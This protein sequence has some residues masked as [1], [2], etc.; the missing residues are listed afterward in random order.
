MNNNRFPISL[1]VLVLLARNNGRLVSS[2]Y[3]AGSINV[4]PVVV[5][6]EISNLRKHGFVESKEGKG[7]GTM[8]AKSAN[9]IFLGDIYKAVRQNAILGQNKNDPN[10]KCPV[11]RQINQ[12]LDNLY[13]DAEKALIDQLS[14]QTLE[15]FCKKFS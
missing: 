11:G 5:R 15:N 1:H 8:L 9:Q 13:A 12:N 7:G 2:D 3:L 14:T 6:K 10:P 4:N